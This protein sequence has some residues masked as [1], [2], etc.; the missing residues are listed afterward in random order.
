MTQSPARS[1]LGVLESI[2]V[3]GGLRSLFSEE[4]LVGGVLEAPSHQ[5]KL[6]LLLFATFQ[7]ATGNHMYLG[8]HHEQAERT[9]HGLRRA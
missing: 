2:C 3:A 9:R 5:A 6:L 4:I 8:P 1:A 7:Y